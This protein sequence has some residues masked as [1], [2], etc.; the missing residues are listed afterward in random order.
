LHRGAQDDL[1]ST[2]DHLPRENGDGGCPSLR[3][4]CR[5]Q[6]SESLG[7]LAVKQ[8]LFIIIIIFLPRNMLVLWDL[9]KTHVGFIGI[10]TQKMRWFCLWEF[11]HHKWGFD[12]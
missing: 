8:M 12:E 1:A 4:F 2:N 9:I 11:Y 3:T 6:A 5:S 7:G 10:K